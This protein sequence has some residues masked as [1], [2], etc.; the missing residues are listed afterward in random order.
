[1]FLLVGLG[2]FGQQYQLTRHNLGFLL[3][4]QIVDHFSFSATENKFHS[5][6]CQ[7]K[8]SGKKI[9]ACKPQTY[10]NRSGIAVSEVANFY[11]ISL[12]NIIVI[13]DDID[14]S[15]GKIKIKQGGGT[16]GHNGLKSIDHH[17]GNNYH[18]I[19]FGIG[20]PEHGV[21]DYVLHNFSNDELNEL[22]PK[23]INMSKNFDL[24][25][26][27]DFEKFLNITTK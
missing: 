25:I 24:V 7:G 21:S 18:R 3:I 23:L 15:F 13:H 11:K 16:G 1:M 26:Q 27:N 20:K 22:E 14:L 9:I 2:N 10:M 19:R 6:I 8:I 4:D 5:H 12:D 17:C